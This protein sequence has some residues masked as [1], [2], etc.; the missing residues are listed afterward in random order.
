MKRTVLIDILYRIKR[1]SVA[2]IG[3]FALDRR[4]V[5]L[6]HGRLRRN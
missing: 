1:I 6:F 4:Y 2:V 3:D 5:R